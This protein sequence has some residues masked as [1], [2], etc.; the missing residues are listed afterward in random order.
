MHV[1][2]EIR[3]AVTRRRLRSDI[4]HVWRWWPAL[5]PDDSEELNAFLSP[6][7]NI[8]A[9]RFH[10][11]RDR[12]RYKACRIYLRLLLAAYSG[13]DAAAIEFR[14]GPQGKPDINRDSLPAALAGLQF[15]LSHSGDAALFAF[16]LDRSI[17]VDVELM[18][19]GLDFAS[20][21]D[22]SFSKLERDSVVA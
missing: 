18:R 16:S 12:R 6:D 17:G 7:E 4:V 2:D 21:A 22:I 9:E 15:N 19:P 11:E 14:Y 20:L 3:Q 1:Q 8:R 10:F 5:A 13:Q